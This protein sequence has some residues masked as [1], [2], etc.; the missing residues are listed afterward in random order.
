MRFWVAA[1]RLH[2]DIDKLVAAVHD[3][4]GG[5][6]PEAVLRLTA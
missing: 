2:G 4:F 6:A 5:F 3:I 1:N